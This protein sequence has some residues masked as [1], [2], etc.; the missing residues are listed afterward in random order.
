MTMMVENSNVG[1]LTLGEADEL[2]GEN[3][4]HGEHGGDPFCHSRNPSDA[5]AVGLMKARS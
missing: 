2:S 4:K 1:S 5:N 3:S